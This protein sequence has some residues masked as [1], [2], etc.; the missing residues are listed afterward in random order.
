[1]KKL[2]KKPSKGSPK[3]PLRKRF[4]WWIYQNN[5]DFINSPARKSQDY[6]ILQAIFGSAFFVLMG[7][8][9]L[10][11][12]AIYLGASDEFIGYIPLIGSI[13]GI[14]LVFLSFFVEKITN[15]KRMVLIFNLISKPL[16]ISLIFIPLFVPKRYQVM[17]FFAILIIAHVLN[18]MMGLVTNSWFVC[19][20]PQQIRGRY[21]SIRQI[22]AVF[23][24]VLLP[25]LG[26]R[27]LDAASDSYNGFA[28][29][30]VIAFIMFLGEIYAFKNIEDVTLNNKSKN[31]F[32]LKDVFL[33]P[34]KHKK[35][36]E[37][38]IMLGIFYLFLY[39]SVSFT[40]LY[41]LRYLKLSYTFIAAITTI[42][43]VLQIFM[44]PKWGKLGD[45][46]GHQ[47]VMEVSI[48]S[49]ALQMAIWALV[50]QKTMY[51]CIPLTSLLSS[52]SN[53]GFVVGSFNKRYDIIPEKGRSIYDG[54]FSMVIGLVL[55]IAPWIGSR[56]RE[57]IESL[58]YV[59]QNIAFGEFRICFAISSLGLMLLQ[60]YKIIF[61]D[62]G[63][64]IR[65]MI[66]KS[67]FRYK[68][69]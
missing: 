5:L 23:V 64:G 43:A 47:F 20:I 59:Q 19:V 14:F 1:M 10:S 9:F 54:F 55:L 31:D 67:K 44:Y 45:R 68:W 11:G 29:L 33:I 35:F 51:V 34:L 69:R 27:I 36:M 15:K 46:Y 28:M 7:G 18:A 61:K 42:D 16:I 53:S 13:C 41:M 56:L 66:A 25:I 57:L 62:A 24:S 63:I 50:S 12:Y 21:F 60:L 65:E 22:Y 26:G 2:F 48:C 38:T 40:Q 3:E 52:I 4:V 32:K 6:F 30:F 39:L 8:Q 17:V 37:Y 49:F 58:S